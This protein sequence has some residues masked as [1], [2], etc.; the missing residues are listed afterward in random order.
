VAFVAYAG[1]SVQM[2]IWWGKPWPNVARDVID[3]LIYGVITGAV[4]AWLWR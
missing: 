4:F 3:G 2:G 1:G